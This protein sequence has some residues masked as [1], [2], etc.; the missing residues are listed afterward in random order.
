[1]PKILQQTTPKTKKIYHITRLCN[2]TRLNEYTVTTSGKC[3]RSLKLPVGISRN[4]LNKVSASQKKRSQRYPKR[5]YH[6]Q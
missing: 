3:N 5:T 4:H 6:S 1:M 2:A